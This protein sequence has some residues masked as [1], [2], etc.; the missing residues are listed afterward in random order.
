M[1]P[2][3]ISLA[4]VLRAPIYICSLILN[5]RSLICSCLKM[6]RSVCDFW[7]SSLQLACLPGILQRIEGDKL[8]QTCEW[9]ASVM[10]E[11][12][13]ATQLALSAL[14]ATRVHTDI[15]SKHK[16]SSD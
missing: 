15:L 6:L 11:G 12:P 14:G 16:M 3:S 7:V 4:V 13:V 8:C 5:P 9:H 1:P 2:D 10:P